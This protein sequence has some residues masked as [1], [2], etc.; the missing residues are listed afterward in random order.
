MLKRCKRKWYLSQYLGLR[1]KD[2]GIVGPRELGTRIHSSLEGFYT[3]DGKWDTGM[4]YMI[5]SASVEEDV[6]T[7]PDLEVDIRKEG[8]LA[9]IML[10]GYFQWVTETGADE[11][12][13]ILGSEQKVT[14]AGPHGSQLM[15]KLDVQVQRQLDGARLF[16]DHKT[17]GDLTGPV[18]GLAQDEQMLFYFLV[19]Y[20][21]AQSR[22]SGERVDGALY[23]MLR[24]VKRTARSNP[25]YYG[26]FEVRH[27][28]HEMESMWI[29]I[30]KAVM[31]IAQMRSELDDGGDHRYVAP[32]N[33]TKDC[34]WDC[35]FYP[36]CPMFDDGSRA[37]DM[38]QAYYEQRDPLARYSN[39]DDMMGDD[40]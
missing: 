34:S 29:R 4:A 12:L 28:E 20:L 19:E 40:D 6:I 21:A 16:M 3:P 26:R 11:G 23:N 7:R 22:G 35:D 15:G 14:V 27:N 39:E 31:E 10:E 36:V 38:V 32:P 33:P 25:P 18:K 24:K 2:Q 9:R 37:W 30:S 8:E 5:L 13:T 17:V 1:L